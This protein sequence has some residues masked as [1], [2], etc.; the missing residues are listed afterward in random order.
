M[1]EEEKG[2]EKDVKR[3]KMYYVTHTT[4]HDDCNNYV[5]QTCTNKKF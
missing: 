2:M 3:I 5:L 1:E 4:A